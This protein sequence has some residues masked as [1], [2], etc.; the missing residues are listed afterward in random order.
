MED[1]TTIPDTPFSCLPIHPPIAFTAESELA[2]DSPIKTQADPPINNQLDSGSDASNHGA[3]DTSRT[4]TS[5]DLQREMMKTE[6]AQKLC[7]D[8]FSDLLEGETSGTHPKGLQ[9]EASKEK[10]RAIKDIY[11]NKFRLWTLRLSLNL[12]RLSNIP[13]GAADININIRAGFGG[14][15]EQVLSDVKA[16]KEKCRELEN[17]AKESLAQLAKVRIEAKDR[18]LQEIVL[19]AR[20]TA[21]TCDYEFLEECIQE[22]KSNL[23]K[24]VR[25]YNSKLKSKRPFERSKRRSPSPPKTILNK[26]RR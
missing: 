3:E 20:R 16:F 26:K 5:P 1:S 2:A 4:S 21:P 17:A 7:C 13:S 12:D 10:L 14:R 18:E 24:K 8:S 22:E 23:Q 15:K 9:K 25:E 11:Q 6:E 19:A